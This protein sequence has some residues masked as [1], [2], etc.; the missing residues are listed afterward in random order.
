MGRRNDK[1]SRKAELLIAALLTERNDTEAAKKAGI[2]AS[3]LKRWRKDET[4]AKA[5]RDARARLVEGAV[6]RLLNATDSAVDALERA[7]TC[8][9]AGVEVRAALGLLSNALRGAELIDLA[10]RIADLEKRIE[11]PPGAT[12]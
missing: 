4:F 6:A 1:L 8:G 3:S 9:K 12:S 11:T 5:Y 10:D 7:L 2:S